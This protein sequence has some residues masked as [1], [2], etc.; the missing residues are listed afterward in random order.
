M[1]AHP[2]GEGEEAAAAATDTGVGGGIGSGSGSG[3]RYEAWAA[4]WREVEDAAARRCVPCRPCAG[5]GAPT[6]ATLAAACGLLGWLAGWRGRRRQGG[7]GA[8]SV[9]C[10]VTAAELEAAPTRPGRVDGAHDKLPASGGL[11]GGVKAAEVEAEAEVAAPA[12]AAPAESCASTETYGEHKGG[13]G[14]DD[15][16]EV[17][18]PLALLAGGG[19]APLGAMYR[20]LL[21]AAQAGRPLDEGRLE[22]LRVGCQITVRGAAGWARGVAPFTP[23]CARGVGWGVPS[24]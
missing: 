14:V 21:L 6:A 20:E 18:G 3:G 10:G 12:A 1:P 8:R 16:A 4:Y 24:H 23:S 9:A 7:G 19:A 17:G 5:V 11:P 22:L 13:S 15:A 2:G